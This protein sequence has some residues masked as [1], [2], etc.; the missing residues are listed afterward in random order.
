MI[1]G[2]STTCHAVWNRG[3]VSLSLPRLHSISSFEGECQSFHRSQTFIHLEF[4]WLDWIWKSLNT[5]PYLQS[6]VARRGELTDQQ[7]IRRRTKFYKT[8]TSLRS[9]EYLYISKYLVRDQGSFTVRPLEH[10]LQQHSLKAWFE[11]KSRVQTKHKKNERKLA[12]PLNL[13]PSLMNCLREL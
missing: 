5:F 6:A 4:Y 1:L 8:G 10:L 2:I 7:T 13:H 12:V 3:W 9:G 11:L